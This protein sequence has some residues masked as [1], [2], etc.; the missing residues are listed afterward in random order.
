MSAYAVI[1]VALRYGFGMSAFGSGHRLWRTLGILTEWGA[2]DLVGMPYGATKVDV[3]LAAIEYDLFGAY[4]LDRA[5]RNLEIT[6]VLDINDD[7][8]PPDG[9]DGTKRFAAVVNEHI[10]TFMDKFLQT[11]VSP[12]YAARNKVPVTIRVVHRT[13][14]S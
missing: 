7:V 8:R 14:R 12:S 4:L 10:E 9:A 5:Q 1:T 2:L 3:Q 6:G 11:L 13:P